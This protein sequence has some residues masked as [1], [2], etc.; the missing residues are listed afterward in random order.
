MFKENKGKLIASSLLTVFPIFIGLVLW[1]ILP[2]RMPTHWGVNGEVDGWQDKTFAVFFLPCF[3]LVMH[4]FT[5]WITGM[6]LSNKKQSKEALNLIF[7]ICPVISVVVN[8]SVYAVALGYN[9]NMNMYLSLCL[10]LMFIV[11][12]IKMPKFEP[13]Y[14]MGIRISSTLKDENNWR[15]THQFGGKIWAVSGVVMMLS[16]FLEPKLNFVVMFLVM[17][18]AIIVPIVYSH[19]LA[20]RQ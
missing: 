10:G 14:T 2:D 15:R 13:N 1:D 19:K 18:S 3:I 17:A 11:F 20:K 4:W 12:G 8:I 5:I 9:F 7:W 16:A 6:D